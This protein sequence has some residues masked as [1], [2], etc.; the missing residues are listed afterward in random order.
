MERY[1]G[2][3]SL[4]TQAMSN[5]M[6]ALLKLNAKMISSI[7][8]GIDKYPRKGM[9]RGVAEILI[10]IDPARVAEFQEETGMFLTIPETISHPV[11]P[12]TVDDD[13]LDDKNGPPFFG[14]DHPVA[15]V[16]QG[17]YNKRQMWDSY[18]HGWGMAHRAENSTRSDSVWIDW[19]NAGARTD[20]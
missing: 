8:I 1:V 7:C 2:K 3:M 4:G 16:P 18:L 20:G 14:P 17:G 15:K 5:V 13:P 6:Y 19:M 10:E 11:S 12:G 9:S